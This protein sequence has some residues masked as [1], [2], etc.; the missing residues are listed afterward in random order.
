VN[1]YDEIQV[2][3]WLRD[4][5]AAARAGRRDEA[6]ELLMRVIEVNERSERA[7]LWLSGVVET[8]EERL[9]CFENVLTLNPDNAQAKAGLRWLQGREQRTESG[10]RR[11]ESEDETRGGPAT[12]HPV[13]Q[14]PEAFMTPDGCVY[15][16]VDVAEGT[17]RCP[18]C[19]ERLT[20][21]QFKRRERSAMA[22]QLHAFWLMLAGINLVEALLIRFDWKGFVDFVAAKVPT[23]LSPHVADFLGDFFSLFIRSEATGATGVE[24][25]IFYVA[26]FGLAGLGLLVALGLFLRQAL[27]HTMGIALIVLC[28]VVEIALFWRGYAGVLMAGP[29]ALY[30]IVLALFMYH[31][32]AD[33][34][35]EERREWL[36]LDRHA[37]TAMDF[38]SQGRLYEKRGMWAKALLHWQRAAALNPTRDTYLAATARAYAR[39]GRHELAL[40]QVDKA[41]E[42]SRTPED[43]RPLRDIIVEMQRRQA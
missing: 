30:T 12:R 26:L 37:A 14:E 9:I 27:A 1:A 15:C 38:Y 5:I 39:L 19:G 31:T 8:D 20:T 23:S 35:Q 25:T 22:Y 24:A 16:G 2:S 13:S 33:F 40:K 3:E 7:W 42:I 29:Q 4:G 10:E 34:E 41:L 21:R 17:S 32:H 6:R 43:L 36:A 18:H 28:L 11:T